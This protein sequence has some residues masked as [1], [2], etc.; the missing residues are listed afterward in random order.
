MESTPSVFEII[1]SFFGSRIVW[2][3]GA[4]ILWFV[5]SRVS[6][7]IKKRRGNPGKYWENYWAAKRVAE[8]NRMKDPSY[9]AQ[10]VWNE[11]EERNKKSQRQMVRE[12]ITATG[13][14]KHRSSMTKAEVLGKIRA[15]EWPFSKWMLSEYLDGS[16][17]SGTLTHAQR[18]R[19]K[20][21]YWKYR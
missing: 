5:V 6:H 4:I 8:E 14:Y 15:E 1:G 18:I 9:R 2:W 12:A 11:Q 10:I 16:L 19:R 7:I 21:Y 13:R 3:L 20:I 17:M